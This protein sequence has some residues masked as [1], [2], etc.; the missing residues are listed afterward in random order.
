MHHL[1]FRLIS[2]V[3]AALAVSLSYALIVVTRDEAQ[4]EVPPL[5]SSIYDKRLDEIHR[6]AVEQAYRNQVVHLFETWMRD[7][8]GQP[9]RGTVG[10]RKARSVFIAIMAELDR[11]APK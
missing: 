5:P 7:P 8:T 9:E 11:R 4:G 2:P 1:T 6:E 3:L 10:A